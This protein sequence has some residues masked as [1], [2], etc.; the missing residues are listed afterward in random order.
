MLCA[1]VAQVPLDEFGETQPFIQL[2]HQQQATV[3]S[4]PRTLEVNP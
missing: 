4:H 2:T 1:P 3:R